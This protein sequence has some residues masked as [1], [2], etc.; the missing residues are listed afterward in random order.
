MGMYKV[1]IVAAMEREVRGLWKMK[2]LEWRPVE[3]E[4]EGRAF[5][6]FEGKDVVVVC[7]GIGEAAARRA[8][9]ALLAVY[10]PTMICSVGFAGAL[11]P[12]IRLGEIFEPA[13]IVRA[14]DGSRVNLGQGKGVLVSFGAVASPEQKAKLR[15]SFGAKLVDMEAAAVACA[16][17]LRGVHFAAVKVVSDECDFEFPEMERFVDSDGQFREEKFA[18]YA[19]LRPWL[20]AKVVRLAVNSRKASE[21][22]GLWL[23]T[24]LQ[25]MIADAPERSQGASRQQ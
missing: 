7:G 20:W 23:T 18:L 3:R 24:S 15:D 4:Y 9:E 25:R 14:G 13:Q 12:G 8:A 21:S 16:A 1:G 11:E 19:A 2:G 22:L 5:R 10:S 17:E 6:F